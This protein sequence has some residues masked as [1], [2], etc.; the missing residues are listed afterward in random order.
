MRIRQKDKIW[1]CSAHT[2]SHKGTGLRVPRLQKAVKLSL[3]VY[4]LS[5]M[6]L[7]ILRAKDSD[8]I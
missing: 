6:G 3:I 1:E 5:F 8:N 7:K 2:M 4:G